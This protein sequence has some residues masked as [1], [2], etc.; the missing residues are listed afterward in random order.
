MLNGLRLLVAGS[1]LLLSTA[2]QAQ[3]YTVS[4]KVVD[5]SGEPMIGVNVVVVEKGVKNGT[6]T[7]I[8]GNYS[9][10][11][12]KLSGTITF[13]Y[14]GY[15]SQTISIGSR[16]R[17]DVTLT[18]DAQALSD[19]VVVGYA[20]QR[21]ATVAAAVSSINSDD[22]VRTSSTTTAGALVGKMSGITA[23]Q[24]SGVPGSA[25]NIQI[26][27]MGTPLFVIDGIM[28]DADAFNSLDIN[29]IE[30][31]SVLK[32]GAAAIYGVK[33][34]NGVVLVTTKKGRRNE[35]THVDINTYMGWQQW[36]KYPKLL[37]A[38][39]YMRGIYAR[40]INDGTLTGD[41]NIANAREELEK[42]RAGY[43]NPET[44]EDYRGY[45]WYDNFVGN[46]APQYYVNASV[47]GGSEKSDYYISLSH[48]DQDAVFKEYTYNRTNLQANLNVNLT[49]RFKVGL[50]VLGKIAK[51][52]NP[53]LPGDDDYYQ[54][55]NSV[56]FLVPT[57]RPYANDNP[58]YLNFI[59]P[60]HDSA[61]NMAA[62]TIDNAGLFKQTVRTMQTTFNLEYDTPLPG[63]K[64]KGM[65]S[66]YYYDTDVYDNEK[67]WSEYTYNR[68]T[69]S[70]NVAYTKADTY[71][72]RSRNN[73]EEI[74]GQ[75]TLNYDY[76]FA[77]DHHVTAVAGFEFYKQDTGTLRVMQNPVENPFVQII[78]TSE[79]NSV[80]N[81]L[82]NITTASWIFR[83]GYAY[84]DKY[85][86]DFAGRE[87]ASWRFKKGNQW[88]FFPSISGAWRVSEEGFYKNLG[89]DRYV[90]NL[91]LRASYGEMG[92]DMAVNYVGTYPDFAYMAGYTF[93]RSGSI[94]STNP[95]NNGN[96]SYVTGSSYDGIPETG[97]TWMKVK[98]TNFGVDLGFF[99]NRLRAEFDVFKRKRTGIPARPTDVLY[100]TEAGYSALLKNLN[101]DQISGYDFSLK[102]SDK[103]SDFKY[104]A[105]INFTFAREKRLNNY[106]ELFYNAWD[107]Y[108]WGRTN[109]WSNVQS[110]NDALWMYEV[111]GIFESQEQID[112][113]PIRQTANNNQDLLPGDVIYRDING[114]GV[115]NTYD[116]RPLGYASTHY[117]W[118]SGNAN[119]QPLASLGINLG[120]EWKGI[121][122]AADF[123][124]GFRNTWVP[125][126]NVKWGIGDD[127]NGYSYAVND[128]WHHEDIFDPTSPWVKGTFPAVRSSN[129]STGAWNN[130]YTKDVNYMRL[131]NLTLGY[132]L[133]KTLT[134]SIGIQKVRV[135]FEGT[136]LLCWDSLSDYGFDPETSSVTGFDYPQHRVYVV[137]L[138]VSF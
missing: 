31:I 48:V 4:G 123:A 61:H 39:E 23:R 137:G 24:N 15:D 107:Q 37:N 3:N 73:M 112:N 117:D 10:S 16:N 88:G 34:A 91:K 59:T 66:Y 81:T 36:T 100:P 63:L 75:G 60:T 124:G 12:S 130:F 84:K 127:Y 70:Y 33:A 99:D 62:Y 120:F 45:D 136:N 116:R 29:D 6:V 105:G 55:R 43:Y 17:I 9:L 129:P 135:Y 49:D 122:F 22:L 2:L 64:A 72:V 53:G 35:K 52:K 121:D 25:A 119:K 102:W 21:K 76:V 20:T 5:A 109:R 7:D 94:I 104:F 18:E 89:I 30:N 28:K 40:A 26:R 51:N 114:D 131:R 128:A 90:S 74:T 47:S 92:D 95:L 56:L 38:Y 78:N 46:A 111:I 79:N 41:E 69:D 80:G 93:G 101:S 126:W 19:V 50:Q 11:V 67:S 77:K 54:M 86:V 96:S 115:I 132:T 118:A 106:G 125:D 133:P 1:F 110:E 57:Q 8:N 32:D 44:G 83:A 134:T 13:S 113:W 85:I 42:W 27:N 97:L 108:K 65:F 58:N 71:R 68:E 82:R 87:D 103:I 98:M 138:N 14:V